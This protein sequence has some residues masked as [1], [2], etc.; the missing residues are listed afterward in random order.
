MDYTSIILN[1]LQEAWDNSFT[2][3]S[4]G[5]SKPA[6]ILGQSV[7]SSPLDGSSVITIMLT[8]VYEDYKVELS[9]LELSSLE[10]VFKCKNEEENTLCRKLDME[11]DNEGNEYFLTLED[12]N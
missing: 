9:K 3:Q 1:Q 8:Q 4:M 7:I 10:L 2:K 5:I 6:E 11:S 12:I